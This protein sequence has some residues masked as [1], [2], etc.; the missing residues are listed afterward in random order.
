MVILIL[1][2][3]QVASLAC[4]AVYAAKVAEN[5]CEMLNYPASFLWFLLNMYRHWDS[6]CHNP[7]ESICNSH[8]TVQHSKDSGEVFNTSDDKSQKVGD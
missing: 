7:T 5:Y 3:I 8:C 6:A 2:Y 1:T 4:V